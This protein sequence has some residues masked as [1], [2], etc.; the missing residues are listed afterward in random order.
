MLVNTEHPW[1]LLHS[2]HCPHVWKNTVLPMILKQ[3]LEK[4]LTLWYNSTGYIQKIDI[5]K[6]FKDSAQ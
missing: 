2:S 1:K 3:L 6:F 4:V 5:I